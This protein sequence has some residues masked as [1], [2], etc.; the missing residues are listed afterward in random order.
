MYNYGKECVL[1]K[2]LCLSV[3]LSS[4]TGVTQR[5]RLS[6][7]GRLSLKTLN[8]YPTLNTLYHV[9]LLS[10]PCLDPILAFFNYSRLAYRRSELLL[11]TRGNAW[12]D[13]RSH[14]LRSCV[15]RGRT[16]GDCSI[17]CVVCSLVRASTNGPCCHIQLVRYVRPV[18]VH[19]SPQ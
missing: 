1:Y 18:Y 6:A 2:C 13:R 14:T 9:S 19:H 4:G 15:W 7:S 3:W 8:L 5:L 12:W 16:S 11:T 10:S 17:M